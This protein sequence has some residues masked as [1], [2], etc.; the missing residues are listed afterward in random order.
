L[1]PW[2]IQHKPPGY[3]TND[4]L[5]LS[6]LLR[7][8]SSRKVGRLLDELEELGLVKRTKTRLSIPYLV[9]TRM[10]PRH[11]EELREKVFQR[12]SYRCVY[13][14]S[15]VQPL[16]CD[17]RIPISRG[18]SNAIGNLATA[19]ELCNRDKRDQTP[20]EWQGRVVIEGKG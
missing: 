16:H 14:G 6:R 9:S 5:G 20:E 10:S 2:A 18:G 7:V 19:C 11:W 8:P 3:L 1:L 17:H 12:D 15:D 4:L 13:C